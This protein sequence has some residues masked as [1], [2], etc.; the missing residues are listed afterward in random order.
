MSSFRELKD[1]Q[2]VV[3]IEDSLTIYEVHELK[4][5]LM[6]CF[7][8]HSAVAVHLERVVE[9]D[10]AG[11]QLLLSAAAT[12]GT[13]GKGFEALAPSESVLETASIA[14]LRAPQIFTT[15][16]EV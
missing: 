14:G 11:I 15:E 8:A 7:A 12:A 6:E 4:R 16:R 9:C 5:E 13:M 1:G 10:M 3:T 2:A